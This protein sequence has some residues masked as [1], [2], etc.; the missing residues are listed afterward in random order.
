M[1]WA[2]DPGDSYETLQ[3]AAQRMIA[4]GFTPR[5][6][7]MRCYV[8]VGFPHDTFS[9]AEQRLTDMLHLGFT[10]MAMLWKPERLAEMKFAP[11]PEW[12]AFQRR[13][14]RPAIIHAVHPV[15]CKTYAL[16]L[17]GGARL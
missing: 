6:H 9:K 16:P 3:S 13:W 4:A 15:Q 17:I 2:Y 1:F 14:V 11:G 12:R 5:S 8:L 7:R 10:P